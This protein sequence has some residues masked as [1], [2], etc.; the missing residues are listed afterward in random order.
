MTLKE[1]KEVTTGVSKM[2]LSSDI[3]RAAVAN[4]NFTNYKI[5]VKDKVFLVLN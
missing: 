5:K 1:T 4:Q 2:W 3:L